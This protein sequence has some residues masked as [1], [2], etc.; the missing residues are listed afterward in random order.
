MAH[1]K[2]KGGKIGSAQT[3]SREERGEKGEGGGNERV[4]KGALFCREE[5][6]L[7]YGRKNR[8]RK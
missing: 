4:K 3:D 5:C 8:I 1:A 6:Q 7:K 2:S